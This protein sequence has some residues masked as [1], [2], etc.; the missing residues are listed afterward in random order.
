MAR[1]TRSEFEAVV[2]EAINANVTAET[3]GCGCNQ[4]IMYGI[5]DAV[6]EIGGKFEDVDSDAYFEGKDAGIS[7]E[8][9]RTN[10]MQTGGH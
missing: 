7:E 3:C 1:M 9:D 8:I 5:A 10:A 4:T 2:R 6:K